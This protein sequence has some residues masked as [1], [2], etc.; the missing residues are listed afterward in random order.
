MPDMPAERSI[1]RSPSLRG[2]LASR[3]SVY[4]V[5]VGIAFYATLD[6]IWPG[7]HHTTFWIFRWSFWHLRHNASLYAHY[8][9]QQGGAAV[10]L[11]KY[12]PTAAMLFAPIALLPSLPAMLL[13]SLV[14]ALGLCLALERLLDGADARLAQWLL[15]LETLAAVQAM[16]SNALLTALMIITFVFIE[17]RQQVGAAVAA[18]AAAAFKIFPAGVLL[19]ALCRP[20]R[21]RQALLTLGAAAVALVLPLLIV[22]PA[23]LLAQYHGWYQIEAHDHADLEFGR[24][25]MT[26]A[27]DMLH[28]A[29]PNLPLQVAGTA[30]LLLPVLWRR[31]CWTDARFRRLVFASV[32]AYVVLF[33]HQAERPT[34]VIAVTGVVIW[35]LG[36]R[37]DLFR[38]VIMLLCISGLQTAPVFAAWL[39]MQRDL[40]RFPRRVERTSGSELPAPMTI[41]Q[42][43]A[44]G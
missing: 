10:D 20:H 21:L 15:A 44:P 16:Q 7:S 34:F 43:E 42:P 19:L 9:A 33:N 8:A 30:V 29:W 40:W 23:S 14:N 32:L 12:S 35:Y 11:F 18:V 4:T 22:T 38:T 39:V 3:W 2:L 6:R 1:R 17:R 25:V 37:R 36:S 41:A 28:V 31:D 26:L 5:Y 13:W 27:R 24:S